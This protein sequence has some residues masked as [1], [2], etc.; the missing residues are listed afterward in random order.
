MLSNSKV[1]LIIGT[2]AGDPVREIIKNLAERQNYYYKQTGVPA[3]AVNFLRGKTRLGVAETLIL[4]DSQSVSRNSSIVQCVSDLRALREDAA[5]IMV[6]ALATEWSGRLALDC[7]KTGAC[8]YL[9]R[10]S[11]D[12]RQLEERIT[13]AMQRMP[14]YPSYEQIHGVRQDSYAF[15][16]TP[17]GPPDARNDYHL[18]IAEAL[19]DLNIRSQLAIERRRV[20]SQQSKVCD[21]IDQS[22]LVIANISQYNLSPNANVYFEIGYAM[23]R[24]IP[25]ILVQRADEE[26]VPSNIGG[27]E[28]L[29][30]INCTDLALKLYFGL[31]PHWGA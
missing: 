9:V 14:A 4:L 16:V 19:K 26:S 5:Q 18:G 31:N 7:I 13:R 23:G 11:Y 10:G 24:K 8:D 20:I 21:Q 17:Y 28:V 2:A 1:A 3:E 30:Y 12:A 22:G 25:V 27:I 6:Y 15:I 29:N